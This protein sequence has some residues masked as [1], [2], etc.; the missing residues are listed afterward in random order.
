MFTH[1]Y[2]TLSTIASLIS[3]TNLGCSW[4]DKLL[5]TYI[6]LCMLYCIQTCKTHHSIDDHCPCFI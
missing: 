5:Y 6:V 1:K 2:T 4:A 3:P